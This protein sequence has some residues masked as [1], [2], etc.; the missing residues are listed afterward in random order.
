MD[1][2][3]SWKAE[4]NKTL[5]RAWV[6]TSEDPITGTCQTLKM[7]SE[8][9]HRQFSDLGPTSENTRDGKYGL[10]SP[11][12]CKNRFDELS[13]DYQKFNTALRIVKSSNPTEAAELPET[14]QYFSALRKVH[15]ENV[16]KRAKGGVLVTIMS[17]MRSELSF[18][19][20]SGY[21]CYCFAS[22]CVLLN[23]T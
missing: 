13:R 18:M 2:G 7:F 15:L 9:L 6:A 10:R 19:D 11:A 21:F 16:L 23:Q 14:Q 12:G 1:R 20:L 22:I 3:K 17:H 8:G 5:A 4:E